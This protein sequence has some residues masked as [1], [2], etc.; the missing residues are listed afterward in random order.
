MHGRGARRRLELVAAVACQ[1]WLPSTVTIGTSSAPQ[2]S[3][4]TAA[5]SGSPC[6]VRSAAQEHE[7]DQVG[8]ERFE[9]GRNLGAVL[10]A[11]VE[12]AGCRDPHPAGGGVVG[13][14]IDRSRTARFS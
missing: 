6:V 4:S 9:C 8:C 2:A 3:A 10:L 13:S 5:C 14:D 1:S 12:V 11:A 7:I